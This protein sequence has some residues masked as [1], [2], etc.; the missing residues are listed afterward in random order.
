MAQSRRNP[1]R[2]NRC[3][4]RRRHHRHRRR[5]RRR[6]LGDGRL[7]LG[8][9]RCAVPADQ[10]RRSARAEGGVKEKKEVYGKAGASSPCFFSLFLTSI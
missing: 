5:A 4:D 6:Q 3:A 2:E 9:R 7:C 8:T 10:H 1:R